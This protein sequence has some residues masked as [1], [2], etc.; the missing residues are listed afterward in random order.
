MSPD[1][2]PLLDGADLEWRDE[3]PFAPRYDDIYYS[4]DASDEVRRVFIEPSCI[5]ARI[6]NAHIAQAPALTIGELGFGT[7]LNFLVAA[8]QVLAHSSPR[9]HFITCEAHPLRADD[10]ARL[11]RQRSNLALAQPLADHPLP[12]LRGWHRRVFAQGRITLSVFHGSADDALAQICAQQ[13]VP[14]DAWFLD[15][16]APARNAAMWDAGLLRQI[17]RTVSRGSTVTTFTAAGQVRRDL[18]AAGFAMRRV[19]QRPLKRESLAGVFEADGKTAPAR[20]RHVHVLGAGIAGASVA[21]HCADAGMSVTVSDPAGVAGG[22]SGIAAAVLHARLL[23]DGSPA[24]A[25]RAA[26][27]HYASHWLAGREGV[28]SNGVLQLPGGS[29][30]PARLELI[31][32]TWGAHLVGHEHWLRNV[33]ADEA[34]ELAGLTVADADAEAGLWFPNAAAVQP[35]TLCANLLTHPGI[36]LRTDTTPVERADARVVC[37]GEHSATLLDL[38]WLE[39]AAVGGQLDIFDAPGHAPRVPLVGRGYL[40]PA[41][42]RLALGATYEY[43]PWAAEQASQHNLDANAFCLNAQA[44][45][46]LAE[47][48]QS[49]EGHSRSRGSR[50]VSSDRHPVVGRLDDEYRGFRAP[51]NSAAAD[52]IPTWLSTAHGSMGMTSAPLAAS[53]I[54]SELAGWLPGVSA[55]VRESLLPQ[56]FVA[57]QARRGRAFTRRS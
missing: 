56:R 15:G 26:A 55:A 20:V 19:D 10:W 52:A 30:T 24:A 50:C 21:R 13:R 18:A 40:V 53:V 29:V 45:A 43:T 47:R 46:F 7:G 9:L 33:S 5:D 54:A 38:D 2:D 51:Q 44:Q 48:L 39:I 17:A 57:R 6:N 41:G 34:S 3:R 28:T 25:W 8:Q 23:A 49:G 32:R 42:A 27:F 14:I 1:T 31:G 16:F 4:H 11:A 37:A 36:E 12:L 22:A 35:Q